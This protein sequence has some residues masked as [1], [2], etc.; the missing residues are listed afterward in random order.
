VDLYQIGVISLCSRIKKL[1][2]RESKGKQRAHSSL[3]IINHFQGIRQFCFRE[4]L[5]S[6]D[7]GTALLGFDHVLEHVTAYV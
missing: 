6:A 2:K 3:K 5:H 1:I 7:Q 4:R